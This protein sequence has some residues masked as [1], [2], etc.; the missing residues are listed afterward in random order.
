[1][2]DRNEKKM[3]HKWKCPKVIMTHN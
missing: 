1:M 3:Q 2:P